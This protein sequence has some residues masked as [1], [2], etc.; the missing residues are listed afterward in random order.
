MHIT[1]CITKQ[2][3]AI[4]AHMMQSHQD[5]ARV[6]VPISMARP[7]NIQPS[8]MMRIHFSDT[9]CLGQGMQIVTNT[10]KH[11][12]K[13]SLKLL[14]PSRTQSSLPCP[15]ASS[16]QQTPFS[17]LHGKKGHATDVCKE[18]AYVTLS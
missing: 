8:C 14:L 15:V 11:K 17:Y 12:V 4:S 1:H 5:T 9:H 2:K 6:T 13:L 18:S 7:T 3:R 10:D 16:A